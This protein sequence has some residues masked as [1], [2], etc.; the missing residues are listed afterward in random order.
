M[1]NEMKRNSTLLY[2]YLSEINYVGFVI[3]RGVL[4]PV[5]PRYWH[6]PPDVLFYPDNWHKECKRQRRFAHNAI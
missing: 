1:C 3:L 4:C 5:M 2:N 6:A